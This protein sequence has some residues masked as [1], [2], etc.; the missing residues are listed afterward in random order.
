M[1]FIVMVDRDYIAEGRNYT[2]QGESFVPVTGRR[3]DAK[4]YKT[5]KMAEKASKRSGENMRGKIK[6]IEVQEVDE[7]HKEARRGTTAR[8]REKHGEGAAEWLTYIFT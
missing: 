7:G 4:R 6:I 3:V 1:S 2:V 5:Y 8:K